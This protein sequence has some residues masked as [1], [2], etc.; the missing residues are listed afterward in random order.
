MITNALDS[1]DSLV[2]DEV[3]DDTDEEEEE[4]GEKKKDD[5]DKTM[6]QGEKGGEETG[7]IKIMEKRERPRN[8]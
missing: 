2:A 8:T 1:L 3:N 6:Y 4:E 5:N 7:L